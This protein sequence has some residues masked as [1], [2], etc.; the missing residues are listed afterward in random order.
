MRK[1][2]F[3][4]TCG[5]I[6]IVV[7][8]GIAAL[9][10]Y[11][12]I[13]EEIQY[14][15]SGVRSTDVTIVTHGTSLET[16]KEVIYPASSE[17][18]LIIPKIGANSKVI[19]NVDPFDSAQYQRALTKGVAHAKGS[20]LPNHTGNSFIFSHSSANFFEAA[21]YNSIFY[22][23]NKMENGDDVIVVYQ[24][25]IFTYTVTEKKIV[26]AGEVWYLKGDSSEP[27]LTLMTC[28]P[29]GTTYKRLLVIAR[30]VDAE[31]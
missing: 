4:I 6:L 2:A 23:L 11:S 7:S 25:K 12:V 28:W 18:G 30:L 20:S 22:L 17:F 15:L 29:P 10:F 19:P 31:I 9:T 1:T 14:R 8:V 27:T 16:D 13:S 21:R 24:E 3:F 26:D 5:M